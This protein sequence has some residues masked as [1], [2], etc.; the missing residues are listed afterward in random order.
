MPNPDI[1]QLIEMIATVVTAI[2]A[3]FAAFLAWR[4]GIRQNEINERIG[5]IQDA[6]EI[7]ATLGVKQ[8]VDPEGKITSVIP[9]LHIQNVGTRHVYFDRYTFNGHI[10]EL[11]GQV[12][13]P[14]YANAENNF[15]WIELPRNGEAHTSVIIEYHDMDGRKWKNRINAELKNGSWAVDTFPRESNE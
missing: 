1:V 8:T 5:N 3:L 14:S 6:V 9:V 7:Y 12:R 15:Y 4:I 11:G 10:H 2:A 13:P